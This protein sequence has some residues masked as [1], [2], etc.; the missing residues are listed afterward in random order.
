MPRTTLFTSPRI[1]AHVFS[2]QQ[3]Q[4]RDARKK[5]GIFLSRPYTQQFFRPQNW[6]LPL[7]R[8]IHTLTDTDILL[9]FPENHEFA[10]VGT[11]F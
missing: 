6:K 5:S 3:V 9:S 11:A 1:N 10:N 7:M 2:D 8:A 4:N